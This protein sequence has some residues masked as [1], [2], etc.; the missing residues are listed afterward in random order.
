[1]NLRRLLILILAVP[2]VVGCGGDVIDVPQPQ[3][4]TGWE[5][6]LSEF[7]NPS[8]IP[9]IHIHITESEWNRLLE[10]YDRNN[11]NSEYFHCDINIVRD[12]Y[13][14]SVTDAGLRLRGNTSR[15]RPE[16]SKKHAVNS[17]DWHHCHFSVNTHKYYEQGGPEF[18]KISRFDLKWFKDDPSYVREIYCFDLFRRFGVWT[19]INNVY[20]RLYLKVSSDSKEAYF[21]VYELMEHIDKDYL[22]ARSSRFGTA[23]GY[24]WKCR[25]SGGMADLTSTDDRLFGVDDNVHSYAY[26]YKSDPESYSTAMDMM[27]DFISKIGSLTGSSF[28]EWISSVMDIDLFLRTYAVN[29]AVGMW[30]DFWNNGNNFYLYFAPSGGSYKVFF[31]PFDY[32][33]T[34]GTS[35]NCGVQSDAGRQDPYKWGRNENFLMTKLLQN[36]EW[37]V[38]YRDYLRQLCLPGGYSSYEEASSRIMGW[39]D[40]IRQY[41]SNDTGED[42]TISDRP[43]SWGN[44]GEYRLLTDGSDNFF[45][46]KA[47][48]VSAMK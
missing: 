48:A 1:M 7:Y 28:R 36:S 37:K 17:A 45:K 31:I 38:S 26:E 33:N 43:A 41:T 27:T 21:G 46:V 35:L 39:Q 20:S 22:K 24:L 23:D 47:A 5:T 2:A 25:Y 14:S 16:S 18:G 3:G 12:G 30:D 13:V 40:M 8:T 32:D 19:A 15:R 42:M 4:T 6:A 44:H 34:L 29:V 9:E 10:E 11:H